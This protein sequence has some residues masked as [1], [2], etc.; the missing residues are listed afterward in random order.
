MCGTSRRNLDGIRSDSG[1]NP[2]SVDEQLACNDAWY[3]Q[4]PRSVC[5]VD[6]TSLPLS[7]NLAESRC[8]RDVSLRTDGKSSLALL[9]LGLE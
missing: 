5:E 8:C 1:W 4:K 9:P 6:P 3:N 7:L 2:S